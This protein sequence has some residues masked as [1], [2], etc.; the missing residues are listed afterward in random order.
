MTRSWVLTAI[1][2][3][4]LGLAGCDKG[5]DS[6][7][8]ATPGATSEAPAAPAAEPTAPAESAPAP[9]ESAPAASSE[10]P[11]PSTDAPASSEAPAAASGS[12]TPASED[13]SLPQACQDYFKKAEDMVTKAG[14]SAE[15]MN[16][17]I[18]QQRTQMA[19][20]KDQAQ[21]ESSCKQALDMLAQQ[22]KN[23]PQ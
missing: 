15:Q 2:A 13:S 5:S 16:Q 18:E 14:G 21:L 6:S 19:A 9:A 11:A 4:V 3:G 17:M 20:I 10:A 22:E 7:A 23:M 8:P 12:S 1:L